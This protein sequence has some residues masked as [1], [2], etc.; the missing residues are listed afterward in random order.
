MY[1][2][3][4]ASYVNPRGV[5]IER[6]SGYFCESE[7]ILATDYLAPTE[8]SVKE[9]TNEFVWVA[10]CRK[11]QFHCQCQYKQSQQLKNEAKKVW[12]DCTLFLC[13]LATCIIW[14]IGYS[15]KWKNIIIKQLIKKIS[16]QQKYHT[17]AIRQPNKNRA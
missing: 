1:K 12:K 4:N 16:R 7:V 2:V 10:F 6:E 14:W 9:W 11:F 5:V 13:K 15:I 3:F 17:S 8:I